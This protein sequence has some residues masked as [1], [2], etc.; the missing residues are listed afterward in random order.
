[1][2]SSARIAVWLLWF[3]GHIVR[4]C[5]S[6]DPSLFLLVFQT[7]HDLIMI[8]MICLMCERIPIKIVL[9]QYSGKFQFH[10]GVN[11]KLDFHVAVMGHRLPH[12][13]CDR[14]ASCS[15]NHGS[16]QHC[17]TVGSESVLRRIMRHLLH[18]TTVQYGPPKCCAV[19]S[20]G[21]AA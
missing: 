15:K 18:C 20:T 8:C 11:G 19:C 14:P 6:T 5:G 16:T 21:S 10:S 12:Q 17:K 1:M 13:M 9:F 3:R 4:V 2:P 7:D